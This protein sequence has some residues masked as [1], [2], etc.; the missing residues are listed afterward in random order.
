[1]SLSKKK[2]VV[3][4]DTFCDII[5][6]D[7]R[8]PSIWGTD[9]LAREISVVAGGSALNI[10][11]HAANYSE[12][13]GSAVTV[14]FF[15]AQEQIFRDRSVETLCSTPASMLAKWLSTRNYALVVALSFLVSMT[16]HL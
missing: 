4:G 1:M 9:T 16:D 8:L 11:L 14:N 2:L 6:L 7:V 3:I 5:A 13:L 10:A 12:F 15:S